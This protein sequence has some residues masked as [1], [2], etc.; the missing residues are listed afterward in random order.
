[1]TIY[2]KRTFTNLATTVAFSP[3][4]KNTTQK[5]WSSALTPSAR[6]NL[7]TSIMN[8][9]S[10][11]SDIINDGQI[12][13]DAQVLLGFK[14]A[15]GNDDHD[16]DNTS[17]SG[18]YNE[19]ENEEEEDSDLPRGTNT[20]SK[21]NKTTPITIPTARATTVTM[22]TPISSVNPTITEQWDLN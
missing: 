17:N 9:V 18:S 3:K 20:N 5:A 13:N 7:D 19:E 14:D 16:D 4:S 2:A 1:M 10:M 11:D 8:G 12:I 21:N 6:K 15:P 22:A